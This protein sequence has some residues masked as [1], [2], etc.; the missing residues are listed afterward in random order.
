MTVINT[1]QKLL[2]WMIGR[3]TAFRLLQR[4]N[5]EWEVHVSSREYEIMVAEALL[6]GDCIAIENIML[7]TAVFNLGYTIIMEPD[8]ATHSSAMN[9]ARKQYLTHHFN[10]VRDPIIDAMA[11]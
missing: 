3:F 6:A 9:P 8:L 7:Y 4:M 11:A 10:D 1:A 2:V 5:E